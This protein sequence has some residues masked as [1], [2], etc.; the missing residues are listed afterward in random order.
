MEALERASTHS[1]LPTATKDNVD[2]VASVASFI[3]EPGGT[4]TKETVPWSRVRYTGYALVV[5]D[6][7]PSAFGPSTMLVRILNEGSTEIDRFT[8]ARS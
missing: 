7:N 2:N 3:N 4:E 8:L 5:V 1:E 6:V